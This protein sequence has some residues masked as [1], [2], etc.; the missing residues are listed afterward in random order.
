MK[1]KGCHAA[2]VMSLTRVDNFA[3]VWYMCP[4]SLSH[5]N[6]TVF[7]IIFLQTVK[8]KVQDAQ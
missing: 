8:S 5:Q 7:V 4:G 2:K 3:G 6:V 1:K